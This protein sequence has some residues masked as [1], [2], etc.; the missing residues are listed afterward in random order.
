MATKLTPEQTAQYYESEGN[1][2]NP[3]SPT[4]WASKNNSIDA[5]SIQDNIDVNVGNLPVAK[6]NIVDKVTS[7]TSG[8]PTFYQTQYDEALKQIEAL[9]AKQAEIGDK[10][11]VNVQ[12]AR[13]AANTEYQVPEWLKQTQAQSVKVAALQGEIDKINVQ[14]QQEIDNARQQLAN[15]PT[16]IVDRQVNEISRKYASQK[17]YKAAELSG[18]AALLQAYSGN[19]GEARN[20]ANDAVEAYVYDIT[21]EREDFDNLYNLYGDWID[22]LDKESKDILYNARQE[23]ID[24]EKNTR[25]EK[26][27]VMDWMIKYP[28]AGIK[29]SDTLE[30]SAK[31]A[32][33]WNINNPKTETT[34]SYKDWT[35]AGGQSGTG[36]TYSEWLTRKDSNNSDLAGDL[37]G[38]FEE[39]TTRDEA[40]NKLE[41]DKTSLTLMYGADGYQKF[42]DEIDRIYPPSEEEIN[43]ELKSFW[44][45][46]WGV[47]TSHI[48]GPMQSTISQAK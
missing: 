41:A 12:D 30:N 19:L 13:D 18:E 25:T 7:G 35:L 31:K 8:L 40:L 46:L 22:S 9:K 11:T 5:G 48:K 34:T 47:D 17:A 14:E 43:E 24:E 28:E 32:S 39:V 29:I 6:T 10:P 1:K 16:Y 36:M 20:L 38:F 3:L 21:Q 27:Q 4:D 44:G 2:A 15:I 26:M 23:I 45:N 37:T 42:K 33:E